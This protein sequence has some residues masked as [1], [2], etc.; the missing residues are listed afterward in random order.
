MEDVSE[1]RT[2]ARKTDRKRAT[3]VVAKEAGSNVVASFNLAGC[4][5]TVLSVAHMTEMGLC[6]PETHTIKIRASLP[7]QAQEATFYHELVHAVLF[8]MG[9][10]NHDEEFVDTFGGLLHQYSRTMNETK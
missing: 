10:T 6:D 2:V 3:A 8:T 4:Q 9:K 5:W 1:T 7:E